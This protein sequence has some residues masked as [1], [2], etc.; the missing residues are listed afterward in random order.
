MDDGKVQMMCEDEEEPLF[1]SF[2][3]KK[4][5]DLFLASLP[6]EN[7]FRVKLFDELLNITA[8]LNP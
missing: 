2:K 4:D 7:W 3:Q 6:V 8:F 1:L 5:R